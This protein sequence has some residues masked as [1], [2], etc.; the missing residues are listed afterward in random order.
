MTK[1][2][3]APFVDKQPKGKPYEAYI[4]AGS[5]A[6]DKTKQQTVLEWT[7]AESGYQPIILGSKQL[8][9]IDRLKLAV[10]V[11]SVAI[12]RAGELSEAN[13]S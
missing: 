2:A 10:E 13:K 1:L 3:K 8:Q 12:Y 11:G 7:K 4:I 6:W 5:N 9:E